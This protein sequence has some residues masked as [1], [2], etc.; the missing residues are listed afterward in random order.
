MIG[1]FARPLLLALAL[2]FVPAA[3]AQ[4][5]VEPNGSIAQ[6]NPLPGYNTTVAASFA[7]NADL[8]F[9][10]L[11]LTEP[12]TISINVWGPTPGVCPNQIYLD[13]TLELFNEVGQ[14]IALND[15]ST[16]LCPALNPTLQPVMGALPAGTYYVKARLL[17][18]L[19]TVQPYTLVIQGAPAPLPIRE[20][21]TYQGKLNSQGLPVNGETQMTFS[22]WTHPSSQQAA[23]RLSLPINFASVELT[24]GLFS[25]D[26]DFTIP[27]APS[28]YNGT[29]RYLQIEVADMN[30]GNPVVLQ[31]RQRLAPTPHAIHALKANLAAR[32]TL[33]DNATN[34]TNANFAGY[35]TVCDTATVANRVDWIDISGKPPAFADNDDDNGGWT[36]V[37]ATGVSHT[38]N[39]VGI[40]TSSPGSFDLAVAGTAAKTG[41]GSWSIFCDERLKHD[42]KPMA[43]TLDRLLQLRGY[44]YEYNSEAVANRLALPGTQIGLLAQEVERVFPDWVAKDAQG[45]RYVTERAT[46]ALMVEALR[47]LR[48]EKDAAI[49]TLKTDAAKRDAENADLKARLE[50]LERAIDELTRQ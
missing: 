36:E 21:F 2:G 49:D 13:P 26:L 30:G 39:N 22:L 40:N 8:D 45:Y 24:D 15:D 34:A 3:L 25:V 1:R 46:T 42:V 31:P 12:T 50:K 38:A 33:A 6:A 28:N 27:N 41:G 35:A 9:Y 32:A 37:A 4:N 20:S 48:A 44:T 23:T 14:S 18:A 17:V 16:S 10:A 29:E 7:V 19:P 11:T 5:E 43:G 47:D